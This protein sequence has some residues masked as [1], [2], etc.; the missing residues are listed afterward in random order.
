M[1]TKRGTALSILMFRAVTGCSC[2]VYRS[3]MSEE[4]PARRVR[5]A[6]LSC[7]NQKF[8]TTLLHDSSVF[9]LPVIEHRDATPAVS[10]YTIYASSH[11]IFGS[12]SEAKHIWVNKTIDQVILRAR[13]VFSEFKNFDWCVSA[14]TR[15]SLHRRIAPVF[16]GVISK[17]VASVCQKFI[18]MSANLHIPHP[19]RGR[20][21]IT[22]ATSWSVSFCGSAGSLIHSQRG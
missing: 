11:R 21:L 18:A 10:H 7:G 8:M 12:P 4:Y 5:L 20:L 1:W 19:S 9:T 2:L 14:V 3:F 6:L 13:T 22:E 16:S 17:V 15:F